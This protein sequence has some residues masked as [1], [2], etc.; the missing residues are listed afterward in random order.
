MTNNIK[1]KISSLE[2]IVYIISYMYTIISYNYN[3]KVLTS[4]IHKFAST[5]RNN[6]YIYDIMYW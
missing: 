4:L 1:N 2:I 6:T 3:N 5:V